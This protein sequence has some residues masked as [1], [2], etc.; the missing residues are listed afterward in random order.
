M[1]IERGQ[2][3]DGANGKFGSVEYIVYDER[4]AGLSS[5]PRPE[6]EMP[7]PEIPKAAKE[8]NTIKK[9]FPLNPPS[10]PVDKLSGLPREEG[11]PA[12]RA[13]AA[14]LRNQGELEMQLAQRLGEEGLEILDMLNKNDQLTQACLDLRDGKLGDHELATLKIKYL[15]RGKHSNDVVR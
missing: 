5:E 1:Y 13:V 14:P 12:S 3:R 6:T 2:E 10:V 11:R 8:V 4:V 7:L 15:T 9:Q